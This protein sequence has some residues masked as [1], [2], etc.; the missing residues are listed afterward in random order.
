MRAEAVINSLLLAAT[1]VATVVGARIYPSRLPQNTTLPAIA[2]QV[3]SGTEI[4]PI[5]AQAG[6]QLMRTRVQVTAMAKNYAE[7]KSAIEAVRLA[8]LYKSGTIAGVKVLSITRDSVGPDLRDD[9]LSIY[10]Q[11]MDFIVLHYES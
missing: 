5:D 10:I 11:S 6:Y 7:V 4:T 2:Y 1:G 8:C 9:E 3:V